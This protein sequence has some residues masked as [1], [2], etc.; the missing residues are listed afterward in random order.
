MARSRR[1]GSMAAGMV[2]DDARDSDT[3]PARRID[4]ARRALDQAREALKAVEADGLKDP[5]LIA[6]ALQAVGLAAFKVQCC[7]VREGEPGG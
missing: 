2:A 3:D 5:A 7:E 1:H 4:R 6:Q